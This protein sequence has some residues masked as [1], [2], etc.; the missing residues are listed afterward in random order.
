VKSSVEALEGNKVKLYVEVEEDEFEHDIDRAFKAIAKEVRLPGF[1]SGKAPRRVLEARI[2]VGPAREQAL[3]DAV[4]SYLARAVREHDVDLIATPE[5]EITDGQESGPVEFDATCEVRPVVTVP[6]YGGLRVELPSIEVDDEALEEA[7]QAEL[8]RHG[9]LDDAG[10]PAETGDF[11]TIDISAKRGDE[12][13]LGLNTEDFSYE[14]G[15]GWVADDFDERLVGASPGDVLTFTTTPKGTGEPADFRVAVTAVQRMVLPELTDAWV[16]DNLAEFETVDEWTEDLRESLQ[17]VRLNQARQQLV[18]KVSDA[19]AAL[20]D[21]EPPETMVTSDLNQR[22]QGTVQQFQA[23]GIEFEQWL[24]ATGQDPQQFVD[25]MRGQSEQAAKVDLALRAVAAAE[26]L[27]VDDGDL[28]VEYA[29]MA[30]QYGQ[31]AREIRRIYERNDA[32]PELMAQIRKSKA[33]DWLIHHVEM[34]DEDGRELDRD[35]VLG[36]THDEHG[37]HVDDVGAGEVDVVAAGA[38]EGVAGPDLAESTAA[39]DADTID[40]DDTLRRAESA[41]PGHTDDETTQDH[42]QSEEDAD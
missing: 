29:R 9:A 17:A 36:H 38:D 39:S 26:A 32:V 41:T 11:V 7:R 33:M 1:R 24:Q 4:P 16:A 19:L 5:V 21:I 2:G 25:S 14:I 22:V 10:R 20:V 30:M 34:V 13:V 37:A 28:E 8:R 27:E 35:A 12:E 40:P 42:P 3:R 15:Q 18:G 6:G 23:Q 31:K